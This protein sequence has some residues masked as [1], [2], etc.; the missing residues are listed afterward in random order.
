MLG[1]VP[2]RLTIS[3]VERLDVIYW[4]IPRP[5]VIAA[6]LA[7]SQE[8]L[9]QAHVVAAIAAQTSNR[10]PEKQQPFNVL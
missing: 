3:L 7:R 10:I 4:L 9:P 8:K 6:I 1:L 2:G 5:H